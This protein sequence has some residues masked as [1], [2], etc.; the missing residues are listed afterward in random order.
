[1]DRNAISRQTPWE[2]GRGDLAWEV[3]CYCV[4]QKCQLS[5]VILAQ[6]T[7]WADAL[8]KPFVTHVTGSIP[9][10]ALVMRFVPDLTSTRLGMVS[11]CTDVCYWAKRLKLLKKASNRLEIV[12]IDFASFGSE[13]NCWK[14]SGHHFDRFCILWYRKR[15]AGN[16]LEMIL[17]KI[18]ISQD[19]MEFLISERSSLGLGEM[20]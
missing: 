10:L 4:L 15:K 2:C 11:K 19:P 16:R 3:S 20:L 18:C 9:T 5:P 1:M 8:G 6:G 7:N 12:L 13:K 17:V 14:S